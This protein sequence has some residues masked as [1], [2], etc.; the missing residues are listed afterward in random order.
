MRQ[1]NRHSFSK[2]INNLAPYIFISP[3]TLFVILLSVFPILYSFNLSFQKYNL[4]LPKNAIKYNG[5]ENYK[6]ILTNPNFFASVQWTVTF[7]VIVVVCN[8]IIGLLLA[9]ILNHAFFE[10]HSLVKTL[11]IMPMMIAPVVIGTIWKLMFA[12]DYGII[13]NILALFSISDVKWLTNEFFAKLAIILVEIWGST[14][15]CLLIL[16]G[17]LKTVPVELY[18]AASVDGGSKWY[19]FIHITLPSIQNFIAKETLDR[20]NLIDMNIYQSNMFHTKMRISEL[21]LSNYL[22]EIKEEELSAKEKKV[23]KKKLDREINEIFY[24]INLPKI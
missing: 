20:Y 1:N 24:G 18:E 17:A 5:I 6:N 9:S 14:P 3:A 19:N 15:F 11:F 2:K 4:F 12:P 16:L 21:E 10:N 22:F 13:N 7:S 8:L 23:I